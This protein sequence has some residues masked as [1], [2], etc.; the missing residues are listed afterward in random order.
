MIVMMMASTPSLNASSR[1]L[2]IPR[3]LASGASRQRP[4]SE[5][6]P[7]EHVPDAVADV[8][9]PVAD[10][11]ERA[12]DPVTDAV[13]QAAETP[14]DVVGEHA[15]EEPVQRTEGPEVAT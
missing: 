6:E 14:Q 7:A 4:G 3:I 2:F 10:A 11:V 13:R 15:D 1:L 12:A 9:D 8:A 5:V